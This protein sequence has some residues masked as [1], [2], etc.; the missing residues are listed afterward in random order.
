MNGDQVQ[1]VWQSLLDADQNSRYWRAMALRYTRRERYTKFFLAFVAS[2]TVA[3][4]SFWKDVSFVWQSLSVIS[5][6]ISIALPII[7]V[8]RHIDSMIKLQTSWFQLQVYYE[9]L[10]AVRASINEA[11]FQGKIKHLKDKE[12]MLSEEAAKL[13]N[14]DAELGA[15]T[16][17][18]VLKERH[19]KAAK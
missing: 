3:G 1:L 7:D 2:A 13:P 16:Y 12:I 15:K 14:D 11:D 18:D 10:W 9:Q 6:L 5:A 17:D 8:P 4:W 19:L